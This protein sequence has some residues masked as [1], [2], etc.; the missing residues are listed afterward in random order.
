MKTHQAILLL[1]F[2]LGNNLETQSQPIVSKPE[3][4]KPMKAFT[5]NNVRNYKK[6]QVCLEDFKGKWLFLEMWTATCRACIAAFPKSQKFQDEFSGRIEFFLVG[7]NTVRHNKGI[8]KVYDNAV[9]NTQFRIPTAFDSLVF[10][11]WDV[12]AVPT[13]FIVDPQ[14]TL[15]FITNGY[16]LTAEKIRDLIKGKEVSFLPMYDDEEHAKYNVV[17]PLGGDNVIS[18]SA[19]SH[20]KEEEISSGY[21]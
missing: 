7:L 4:G 14:G 9:K 11:A 5:F 13:I 17:Q 2:L 10:T 15:R 6:S 16:D 20:W 3:V 21:G 1:I 12:S 8:E 19:L 18:C